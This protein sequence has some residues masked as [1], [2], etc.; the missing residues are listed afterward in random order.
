MRMLLKVLLGKLQ[1]DTMRI[2]DHNAV[3]VLLAVK[4]ADLDGSRRRLQA[5]ISC[6]V[7]KSKGWKLFCFCRDC[8]VVRFLSLKLQM[9]KIWQ[10]LWRSIIDLPRL[11]QFSMNSYLFV[12]DAQAHL[13]IHSLSCACAQN[14][15]PAQ[16]NRS[17]LW[18][19]VS[20]KSDL[21]R[22]LKSL[23]AFFPKH[24]ASLFPTGKTFQPRIF[25]RRTIRHDLSR[26]T[27]QCAIIFVLF[28]S[29]DKADPFCACA[30][31][32]QCR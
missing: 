21:S 6:R 11:G 2:L 5:G 3:S 1:Q 18:Q 8:G 30:L 12:T 23:F 25:T 9:R 28:S 10:L 22:S 29:A 31:V 20:A 26:T 32:L 27:F 4:A 14:Q 16:P 13:F 24:Q 19:A 17:P 7:P 15:F